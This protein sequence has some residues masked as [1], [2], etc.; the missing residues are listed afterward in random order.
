MTSHLPEQDWG[1]KPTCGDWCV[2]V[3]LRGS[4]ALVHATLDMS[5]VTRELVFICGFA[6]ESPYQHML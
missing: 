5:V 2:P 1:A 4:Y 3:P 6:W